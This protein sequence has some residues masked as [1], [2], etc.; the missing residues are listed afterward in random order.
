MDETGAGVGPKRLAYFTRHFSAVDGVAVW[1]EFCGCHEERPL[2][3]LFAI[4]Y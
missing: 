2:R 4:H 1:F 3:N